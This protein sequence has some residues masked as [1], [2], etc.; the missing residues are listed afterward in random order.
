MPT[1][2]ELITKIVFKTDEAGLRRAQQ[3]ANNILRTMRRIGQTPSRVT[4]N[5][6]T[7]QAQTRLTALRQQLHNLNN[8]R[9][10]IRPRVQGS[11]LPNNATRGAGGAI[12]EMA[13]AFSGISSK[14]LL[15]ATAVAGIGNAAASA[16]KTF[17]DF[18]ATMS[19]VKA[20]TGA[21]GKDFDS[22]VS[23]AEKLGA[24]TQFSA[25]QAAEAMS[26]LGMAG[27]KTKQ[28]IEGM[29]GLL[30][31][32]AASGADL[33]TA[34]DIVSDTLTAMN[35][36]A[37]DAAKMA[38]VMAVAST[39]A[40][41][42]VN[43]MGY[44]F[45]YVG[46]V[47]GSLKYSFEDLAL[48][49]GLLANAGIKGEQA[50][51][52]LRAIMTRLVDP[53]KEAAA[54]LAKLGFSA[55]TAD[56]KVK[57]FREQIN[58]LRKA[59]K[60]LSDA[61]KAVMASAI[62]GMEAQT[63]FSALMNAA[64]NDMLKYA[65]AVDHAEGAAAKAAATM[66]DNLK[67]ALKELESATEGVAMKFG[68][69]FE[70]SVKKAVKGA[71]KSLAGLNKA[72]GDMELIVKYKQMEQDKS[73]T[74]ESLEEFR[75]ENKV[76]DLI[77]QYPLFSQGYDL[78][79]SFLQGVDSVIAYLREKFAPVLTWLGELFTTDI[80]GEFSLTKDLMKSGIEDLKQAWENLA[81]FI[82][83][84]TP[85]LQV[86]AGFIGSVLIWVVH[87]LGLMGAG[88]FKMITTAIEVASEVLEDFGAAVKWVANELAYL[89]DLAKQALQYLGLVN[90][91]SGLNATAV[92]RMF[93]GKLNGGVTVTNNITQNNEFPPLKETTIPKYIREVSPQPQFPDISL[94]Y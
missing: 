70:P 59:F 60:G 31:L 90:S 10:N 14:A 79:T 81:P 22:L 2:R 73:T 6:D 20:L 80:L 18:D 52:T 47:A 7:R 91:S 40:N 9:V 43:L 89:I 54:A 51:T 28:I 64:E 42:N 75:Q 71:Q 65:N 16:T 32:A 74:S 29:P 93:A 46:A 45:K 84:I 8:T 1:V 62:A 41:T 12:S 30:S 23:T 44:T 55:T 57:P 68:K 53:P 37:S 5:A 78:W 39:N 21:T 86:M 25:S 50:G 48:A 58:A 35:M 24:S 94:Y 34:A 83:A 61:D 38:D 27:W 72:M 56:G 13:G 15:T 49:T 82:E 63:G 26:Y 88:A 11:N 4:V 69:V 67:G 19:K 36:K 33:A 77:T 76:E 87:T 85:L 66:N 92:D 3:G 17:M